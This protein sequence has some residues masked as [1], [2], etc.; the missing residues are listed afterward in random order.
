MFTCK[1]LT[2]KTK[3]LFIRFCFVFITPI[4]A[5]QQPPHGEGVKQNY[6]KA[7]EWFEKAAKQ[8]H[9]RAQFNLGFMYANGSGVE[10]SDS[11]AMRWYGRAAAQGDDEAKKRCDGILQK[12]RKQKQRGEVGGGKGS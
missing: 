3:G 9:A 7:R 2:M 1:W 10:Q 6:S 5:P 8:G 12:R 4:T 11:L